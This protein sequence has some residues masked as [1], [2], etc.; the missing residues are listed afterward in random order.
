MTQ[1]W[2]ET[3]Q[4]LIGPTYVSFHPIV[5]MNKIFKD[6]Q[7]FNQSGAIEA[8]LDVGQGHSAY[9]W[10]KF[11]S[12]WP[13]GSWEQ[14]QNV[15]NKLTDDAPQVMGNA[16]CSGEL[17]LLCVLCL[18]WYFHNS[19]Y[20]IHYLKKKTISHLQ[21]YCLS[22]STYWYGYILLHTHVLKPDNMTWHMYFSAD[23]VV[24]FIFI[25]I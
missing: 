12:F 13:S 11:C 2:K 20:S 8:N 1:I 6:F 9:L 19:S 3:T 15:K 16:F 14:D 22:V 17:K 18:K 10:K 24:T 25:F 21:L 4:G 7:F 5:L 23:C